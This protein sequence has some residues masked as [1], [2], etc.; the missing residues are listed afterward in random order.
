MPSSSPRPR[1]PAS[2][3]V[4]THKHA[5]Y[6]HTHRRSHTRAHEHTQ[7]HTNITALKCLQSRV[8]TRTCT[9][10]H[11]RTCTCICLP[12]TCTCACHVCTDLYTYPHKNIPAH[13]HCAH[14]P[15]A[16]Q[17]QTHTHTHIHTHMK[18]WKF[19]KVLLFFKFLQEPGGSRVASWDIT[20]TTTMRLPRRPGRAQSTLLAPVPRTRSA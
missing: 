3:R 5:L 18:A 13:M 15:R 14:T 20:M 1:R 9:H 7:E 6:T 19:H 17:G 10:K 2:T 4:Y 11:V 16:T 8:C 12:Y